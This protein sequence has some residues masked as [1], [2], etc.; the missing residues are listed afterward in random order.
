MP[1]IT[2][3]LIDNLKPQLMEQWVW[4]SEV[5]GFG[6]R[7]TPKG[8]KVYVARYR[9]STGQQ[10]K[11]NLA[12]CS[13]MPPEKAR[14]LARETFSRVAEGKDPAAEKRAAVEPASS[15]NT[16]G[17]MFEAYVA[18]MRSKGRASAS[19]VER[20]LLKAGNNVADALG[21]NRQA[22]D[23]EPN[24]I[25]RVLSP[26]FS[27]GRRGA[28]DKTRSYVASA[29]TW[30]IQSANDYTV[31]NRQVWGITRNPASE[32]PRDSG[33][34]TARDRN[35]SVDELR[36]LWQDTRPGADGFAP[37]T[38]ACIRTLIACGQRVQE[39]LRMEAHEVDAA[40]LWRMPPEKTK[41]RKHAHELPLPKQI[42]GDLMT[43]RQMHPVGHFFVGRDGEPMAHQSIQQALGRWYQRR[44]V[45]PFQTRDL[46][47]TWK[48]RAHDAGVD[49]FTRDLIQQH[50]KSDSG[51]K[52]YDRADYLPQVREAMAKWTDWIDEHLEDKPALQLVA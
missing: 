22:N 3:S 46:R 50:A 11:M 52:H 47:R 27:S 26:M 4:D 38:A 48:S 33:A 28:A 51:S 37:E 7:C 31:A 19:E 8:R 49:R 14:Q 24:E 40:G 2:K 43:I 20:V 10:R 21:R 36:M 6:V 17:L 34:T 9:N 5:Q 13:D 44:G 25:V 45:A 1:K 16:V 42:L 30:A 18:D 32:I 23:I 39:T 15:A 29:Y 41:G 12:R 35:L